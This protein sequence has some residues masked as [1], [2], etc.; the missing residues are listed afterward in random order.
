MTSYLHKS[1]VNSCLL[2]YIHIHAHKHKHTHNNISKEKVPSALIFLMAKN[3]A[4]HWF[5]VILQISLLAQLGSAQLS[6]N[7]YSATCPQVETIVRGAV[8]KKFQE[9]FS[10]V[11][12]VVRLM[13]HDCFVQVSFL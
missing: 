12:G 6:T 5:L 1:K 13:F 4:K 11:G 9:T 7:Y 10:A 8:T 3:S 2:V